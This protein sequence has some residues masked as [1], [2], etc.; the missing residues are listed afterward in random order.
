MNNPNNIITLRLTRTAL[1][2]EADNWD[3]VIGE[4]NRQCKV[5]SIGFDY[6]FETTVG[7]Q[8]IS[9][10]FNPYIRSTFIVGI[11]TLTPI[12][13]RVVFT[14]VPPGTTDWNGQQIAFYSPG[15]RFFD[16]F[17]FWNE[18]E[19]RLEYWNTSLIEVISLYYSITIDFEY[20]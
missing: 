17:I 9:P 12:S 19:C 6:F 5:K 8:H 2:N 15:Q 10:E 3:F 18:I 1:Q 13:K 7:R 20:V 14:S 16:N 4:D 11:N